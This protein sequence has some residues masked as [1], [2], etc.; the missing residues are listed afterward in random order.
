MSQSLQ[1]KL[2]NPP[3]LRVLR[4]DG[5]HIC[6]ICRNTFRTNEH[7]VDCLKTCWASLNESGQGI[8]LIIDLGQEKY[9][10]L[11]CFRHYRLPGEARACAEDCAAKGEKKLRRLNVLPHLPVES[12][13]KRTFEA[14]N[15]PIGAAP[16]QRNRSQSTT[17]S[18]VPKKK[19]GETEMSD[20]S[21]SGIVNE[22][23]MPPPQGT[24]EPEKITV[25]P[26]K[27][28]KEHK[29][30]H[31]KEFPKPFSRKD[32]KYMCLVCNSNYFTKSEV[33]SCFDAHFDEEGFYVER[34]VA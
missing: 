29:K 10:C 11:F 28:V 18:D 1:L 2:Q 7:A 31:K 13:S 17:K 34:E 4:K 30:R 6:G 27:A 12:R 15:V 32:A 24:P 20:L 8:T 9:L 26:Q 33:E 19:P 16:F 14:I 5:S 21:A 23:P 22:A 25:T 3:I